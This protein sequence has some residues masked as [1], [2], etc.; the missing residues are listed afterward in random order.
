MAFRLPPLNTLRLFEA[1]GRHLSFKLAAQELGVTPSA[2]SHGVHGLEDWLGTPLFAR[3]PRGLTLTEAGAAYLPAVRDALTVLSAASEQVPGR[4]PADH[5]KISAAPTFAARLLLPRLGRFRELH[6]ETAVY[7]DTTHHHVEFPRD[8]ADLAIRVGLGAWP[9]LQATKI[10]EEELFPV[11]APSLK[12]RYA[13]L[14]AVD[15]L[16]LIHV[17][18]VAHDW[19]TWLQETGRSGV[20]TSRG[21]RVDTIQMAFDAAVRGMGIVMGRRPLVDAELESGALVPL[22]EQSVRPP[23]AYWLVGLPE[24]MMRSDIQ[25]FCRWLDEE[26]AALR[27]RTADPDAG[28][29]TAARGTSAVASSA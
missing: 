17:T 8:G 14:G 3:G 29:M 26:L 19:D 18:T 1:A 23:T 16:P 24:T 25:A 10:L 13:D 27:T 20:D 9:G 2:V 4:K 7:I 11:C 12:E 28:S 15:D 22:V 5:I 6:P 21:L